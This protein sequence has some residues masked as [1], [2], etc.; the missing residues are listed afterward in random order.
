MNGM[1][2][3]FATLFAAA[4]TGV[5]LWIAGQFDR[6]TTG[7][8]WAALGLIAAGGLLFGLAQV[9]G[10]HGNPRG[11]LLVAFLPVAIATGWILVAGEPHPNWFA[12]HVG[13]WS[14]DLGIAGAVASLAAFQG[15]L[16]FGLGLVLGISLEPAR[17]RRSAAAP[18]VAP[19]A[20]PASEADTRAAD[21]P[22]T[23]ERQEQDAAAEADQDKRSKTT[24]RT[25]RG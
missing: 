24:T 15:V 20:F 17:A 1:T 11:T 23:A 3:A 14:R 18:T 22:T 25:I 21:E 6:G 9:R 7:G 2:R 13:S 8:Y 12:D 10:A 16:A 5:L 19:A 4:V